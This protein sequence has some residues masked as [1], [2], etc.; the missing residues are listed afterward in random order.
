MLVK[1]EERKKLEKQMDKL[2]KKRCGLLKRLAR[3]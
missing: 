3:K 2:I 1:E